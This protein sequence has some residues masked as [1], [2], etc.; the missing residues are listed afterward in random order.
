MPGCDVG[1]PTQKEL[2]RHKQSVHK[3]QVPLGRH[4]AY[5]PY[6]R[7]DRS[8]NGRKEQCDKIISSVIS[9]LSTDW[10]SEILHRLSV[11]FD[12]CVSFGSDSDWRKIHVEHTF[13]K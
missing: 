9:T 7:C 2:E 10:A 11:R 3:D 4:M 6:N 1:C 13:V 5:W 12:L 8:A